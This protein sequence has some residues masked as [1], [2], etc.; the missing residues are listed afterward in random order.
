[1]VTVGKQGMAKVFLHL[2]ANAKSN[3]LQTRG[4]SADANCGR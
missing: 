3:A 1:M 2:K 4:A